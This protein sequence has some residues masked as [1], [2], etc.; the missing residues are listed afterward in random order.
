M[1]DLIH[2]K[3]LWCLLLKRDL[4]RAFLQFAVD[5]AD[6]DKLGFQ[7]RGKLYLE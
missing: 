3:G 4:N 2:R 5:P 7:W 1:V 6:L